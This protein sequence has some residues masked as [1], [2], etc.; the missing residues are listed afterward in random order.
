MFYLLFNDIN[1]EYLNV[2]SIKLLLILNL[3]QYLYLNLTFIIH[4]I[5]LIYFHNQI[6]FL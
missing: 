2:F 1:S 3:I 5:N 6:H 4:L